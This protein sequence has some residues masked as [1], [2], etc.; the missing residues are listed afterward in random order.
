MHVCVC[1]HHDKEVIMSE[2]SVPRSVSS[3]STLDLGRASLELVL[4]TM[5][6]TIS[7]AA[8]LMLQDQ[9]SHRQ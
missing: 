5:G 8:T 6:P 1:G 2:A 3:S 7:V 9:S 4:I